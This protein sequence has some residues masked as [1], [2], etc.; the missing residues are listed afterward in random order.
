MSDIAGTS[1][2]RVDPR[3][4]AVHH[5][6]GLWAAGHPYPPWLRQA[7]PASP[8]S[9]SWSGSGC[10]ARRLRWIRPRTAI[11]S[12]FEVDHTFATRHIEWHRD[13]VVRDQPGAVDLPHAIGNPHPDPGRRGPVGQCAVQTCESVPERHIVADA[14]GQVANL[15]DN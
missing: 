8:P 2:F 13:L 11:R 7:A 10:R 3:H 5:P 12:R 15:I 1:G 6:D 9:A 14:E 4:R